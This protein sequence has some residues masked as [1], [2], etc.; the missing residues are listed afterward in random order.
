V[1]CVIPDILAEANCADLVL[2][3]KPSGILPHYG[4]YYLNSAAK[5]HIR[6]GQVGIALTHFNTKSVAALVVAIPPLAE[7]EAIVEAVEDQF[8]IIDH[9]EVDLDAKFKSAQGLR[10]AILRHAFTGKLVRQDPNDEPSSKLLK[11]IAAER[12]A[13]ARGA[14]V[15]KLAKKNTNSLR[16]GRRRRPTTNKAKDD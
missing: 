16:L 10:H 8:S 6:R 4:A 7:Q 5:P 3:Q 13:R 14:A 9:L 15:A 11:R 1:S 2:I 12:E